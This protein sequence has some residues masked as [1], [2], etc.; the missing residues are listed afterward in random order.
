MKWFKSKDKTINI[1]FSTF[2]AILLKSFPPVASN[3]ILP[4]W[5]VD[6]HPNIPKEKKLE[7]FEEYDGGTIRKCPAINDYLS[8]GYTVPLWTDLEVY[9]NCEER[10]LSWR[11]A[12]V[13]DNFSMINSHSPAQYPQLSDKYLHSKIL[14]P[15]IASCDTTV[16]WLMTK[17]TYFT[18]DFDGQSI[19]FCD[20]ELD[21]RHN[22]S[23]HV[24][25]F[26]PIKDHNYHVKF[27]AGT[28]FLKLIP[29]TENKV[30]M[31]TNYCTREYYDSASR[32]GRTVT[33]SPAKLY[34]K[35]IKLTK[36]QEK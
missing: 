5:F 24:N 32:F 26:F 25:L 7:E 22:F 35:L 16:S 8:S 9:V 4:K 28:P 18:S 19:V 20:G 2:D 10:S 27:E 21:F 15:W 13:Y 23:M 17:P 12:N 11:F 33:F 6:T 30:N 1:E 34:K 36:Q 31:K 3:K 29:I 14:C